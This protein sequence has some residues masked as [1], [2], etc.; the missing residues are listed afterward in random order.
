MISIRRKETLSIDYSR[1]R[2]VVII[3]ERIWVG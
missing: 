3:Y 1:G 2:M